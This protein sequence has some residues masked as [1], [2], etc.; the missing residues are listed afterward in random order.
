ME[1]AK[2]LARGGLGNRHRPQ[3][4]GQDSARRALLSYGT[5]SDPAF[6]AGLRQDFVS[7]GDAVWIGAFAD[8]QPAQVGQIRKTVAAIGPSGL[9]A[10]ACAKR[11]F[12]VIR[13]LCVMPLV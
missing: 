1:L 4:E 6:R 10:R 3:R 13:L 9:A 11:T 5:R 8:L 12:L 2:E 7:V